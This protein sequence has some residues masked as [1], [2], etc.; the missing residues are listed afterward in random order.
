M[1]KIL[2]ILLTISILNIKSQDLQWAN[3]STHTLKQGQK[4]IGLFSPLKIG[5]KNNMELTVFPVWFF[6]LPNLEL[7]KYWTEIK[8]IRIASTHKFSYPSLLYNM[9]SKRG[10]AGILPETSKIPQMFKF[11]NNI[12]L[13]KDFSEHLSLTLTLGLDL[14]LSFG[15]SDFPEIEYYLVYPRTYS[16]NNLLTPYI[17]LDFTGKI[18]GNFYYNYNSTV[19]FLTQEYNGWLTEQKLKIQWNFA[20]NWAVKGGTLFTYGDYP[21]GKGKGWFPIVDI[22]YK[23]GTPQSNN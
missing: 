1:K 9:I 7:K 23:F 20:E 5:M 14:C 3:S 16:Y 4:E 19:F 21:Y 22:M 15:E 12:M 17:S 13:G 11:N 2:F 18:T 10:I 6:I 8:G